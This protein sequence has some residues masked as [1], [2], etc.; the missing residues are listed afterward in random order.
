MRF[1]PIILAAAILMAGCA[2]EEEPP[3]P[4]T[5]T[6]PRGQVVEV[7]ANH[8]GAPQ[9]LCPKAPPSVTLQAPATVRVFSQASFSWNVSAGDYTGGHSMLTTL[10]WSPT[11]VSNA[12]LQGPDSYGTE[13]AKKEHQNLPVSLDG[14]RRFTEP[15]TYYVRAY[16][17]ILADGYDSRDHWSA[18]ATVVV[19][20]VEPTGNNTVVTHGAGNFVGGLTPNPVDLK[21]GDGIVLKNDDVVSHTFT[22][23]NC[24]QFTE[25]IPVASRT[26]SDPLVF[27][28]PGTCTFKTDD[29]Q[30]LTLT[31]NVGSS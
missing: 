31:I 29:V 23:E 30:P 24:P 14:E 15:G 3:A 11:P 28:A 20:D 19:T 26:S 6:C 27:K 13:F 8:T 4:T 12:S 17:T 1:T 2:A 16:A 10:R 18:E 5:F 25:A 9:A 22:P 21:L 7:P